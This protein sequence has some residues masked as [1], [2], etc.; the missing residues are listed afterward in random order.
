MPTLIL[1][2]RQTED[3]QSLWKAAARLGWTTERLG[4]WRIPEH[5]RATEEPVVYAEAL[6][7][8]EFA[9]QLG[10]DLLSPPDD[11]LVGLPMEYKSREIRMAT[12]G[13]AR[14]LDRPMFVKPPNDKTFPAQAYTGDTLPDGYDDAMPVLVSDLVEWDA[15]FRCFV[16]DRETRT[17]SVYSRGGELQRDAEFAC[18]DDERQAALDFVARML[19]DPRVEV[20][21]ACVL[22]VGTLADGHWACVEQNAA[23]GAGLYGCDPER[24]LDVI[25]AA[26]VRQAH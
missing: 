19:A 7:G 1:S 11:W 12:L 24:A 5:L 16:L 14:A 10:I 15:E 8:P 23:W 13:E 6:F 9:A 21:R 4:S 17:C 3:T 22:D 20:P 26:S 18:G 25:R 2:P